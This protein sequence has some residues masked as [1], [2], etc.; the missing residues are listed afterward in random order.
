MINPSDKSVLDMLA[1]VAAARG[2]QYVEGLVDMANMLSPID[3]AR[4]QTERP[5]V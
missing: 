2:R 5:G 4:E 3:E 1:V